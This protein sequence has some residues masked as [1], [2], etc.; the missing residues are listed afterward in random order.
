MLY[1]A[2]SV[3]ARAVVHASSALRVGI[4]VLVWRRKNTGAHFGS[5]FLGLDAGLGHAQHGSDEHGVEELHVDS[6]LGLG[7]AVKLDNEGQ[8]RPP[9]LGACMHAPQFTVREGAREKAADLTYFVMT[10]S[11]VCRSPFYNPVHSVH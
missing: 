8:I 2:G 7:D 4:P 11:V 5:V 6:I 1:L 10:N 9:Y 3:L